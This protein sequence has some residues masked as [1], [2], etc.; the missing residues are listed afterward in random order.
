M[1][2]AFLFRNHKRKPSKKKD[3]VEAWIDEIFPGIV[4]EAK[5]LG[6]VIYFEDESGISLNIFSGRTWA[7]RGSTPIVYRSG[8]RTKRTMAAA[9]SSDG[10][11][12]FE[13]YPGGTNG[14][15]YKEFLE[16][17][18][19]VDDR[20]KFVIHD[21]LPSHRAKLVTEYVQTTNGKLKLFQLPG[22]S[23]ELNPSEWVWDNMKKRLGKR[24]HRNMEDLE[25]HGSQIMNDI[26]NDPSLIQSFYNHIYA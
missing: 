11:M 24:A 22:Y 19:N 16:H 12:Y 6:A 7:R 2:W 4:E 25:E 13:I 9:I 23:P 14:E 5:A 20:V 21:G 15:R 10:E 18:N 17:L 3:K 1:S 8:Q 26:K